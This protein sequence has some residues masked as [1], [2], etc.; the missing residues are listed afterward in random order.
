MLIWKSLE[1]GIEAEWGRL[2][3]RNFGL[4]HNPWE[5]HQNLEAMKTFN[6]V[7]TLIYKMKK[8]EIYGDSDNETLL[9]TKSKET[10][11]AIKKNK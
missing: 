1:D 2:K 5:N 8:T 11:K 3:K 6:Q 4:N 9:S 10:F 7:H